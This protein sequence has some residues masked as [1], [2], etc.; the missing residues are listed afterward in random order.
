MKDN[1]I[2]VAAILNEDVE[3]VLRATKYYEDFFSGRFSCRNCNQIVTEKN[4]GVIIPIVDEGRIR[5]NFY[6]ENSECIE[7]YYSSNNGR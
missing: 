2:Q 6:C 3:K 5:L 7:K 4:L 1:P